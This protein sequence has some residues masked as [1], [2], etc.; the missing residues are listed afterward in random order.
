[1]TVLLGECRLLLRVH[2]QILLRKYCMSDKEIFCFISQA[3]NY[4]VISLPHLIEIS[5]LICL[6]CN[7]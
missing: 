4:S 7:L 1:M 5:V 2:G 3:V 6:T